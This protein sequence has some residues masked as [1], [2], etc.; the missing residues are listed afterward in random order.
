MIP[1]NITKWPVVLKALAKRLV[2]Y[3]LR[4]LSRRH[5]VWLFRELSESLGAP[6][7]E[8][9]GR[10]GVLLGFTRDTGIFRAYAWDRA[11]FW[12]AIEFINSTFGQAKRGTF[13]D[14]GA[15]IGA[16]VVPIARA[17][18]FVSCF[19]FEP[20]PGNYL[21]LQHNLLRNGVVSNVQSFDCGLSAAKGS[22]QF[23]LDGENFGDHRI[24][25]ADVAAAGPG[26]LNEHGR[27]TIDVKV[28][29]LDALISPDRLVHPVVIKLD[30]Q[31]AEALVVSGGQDA[32]KSADV[33]FLE[34]WPYGMRRLGTEPYDLI[35]TLSPHFSFGAFIKDSVP[36]ELSD[37]VRIDE[38][39]PVLKR[40]SERPDD[41]GHLNL[42]LT[43][44]M[45]AADGD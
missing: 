39:L 24:R 30:V 16:V 45:S 11:F 27:H 36:I 14:I 2:Q 7:A 18:P 13:L 40:F 32:F 37:F 26:L 12:N 41:T 29:R 25:L 28:D 19:A 33:L 31:G 4:T 20:E 10:N 15:N 9:K 34:Y 3:L 6:A 21:M 35:H 23:E 42:V 5:R 17:N 8:L 22:V 1:L 44:G 38:I 43:K